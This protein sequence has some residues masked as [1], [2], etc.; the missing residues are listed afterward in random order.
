MNR[1]L[2]DSGAHVMTYGADLKAQRSHAARQ[3]DNAAV[4]ILGIALAYALIAVANTLIMAMAGRRRE[5]AL[6]GLAGT[7]RGQIVK[8]A[9]AESAVA[10]VVGTLLAAVATVL[11]AVTQHASL[12]KL[13]TGAPTVI[14][15]TQ[16]WV[17]V[18]LCALV[19]LATASAATLSATHRRAIEGAGIRE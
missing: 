17:T 6:L 14:P 12:S 8:V 15:W 9:A 1:A 16:I 5:F 7:V 2:A 11:A 4:V 18:A 10:V 3:T 13:V 19:A